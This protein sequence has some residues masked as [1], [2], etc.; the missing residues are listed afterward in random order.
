MKPASIPSFFL[1]YKKGILLGLLFGAIVGPLL[2]TLGIISHFFELLRPLLTGPMD[3]IR[4]FIPDRQIAPN[5]FEVPAYKWIIV[6]GFNGLCYALLG[7]LI[8][9]GKKAL[10]GSKA[11]LEK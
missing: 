5:T 10:D 2:M 3:W 1:R 7:G 8:Q 11:P 6:L 9:A 4:Q